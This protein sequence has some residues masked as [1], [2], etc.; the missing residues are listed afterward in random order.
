MIELT[1]SLTSISN[2]REVLPVAERLSWFLSPSMPWSCVALVQS[3]GAVKSHG[4]P[5]VLDE[6]D[7]E[8]L[9]EELLDEDVLVEELLDE[10]TPEC[11]PDPPPPP[12]PPPPPPISIVPP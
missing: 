6:L 1:A 11:A 3:V 12:A 7:D 4:G 10:V 5:P 2:Q 8:V 9:V